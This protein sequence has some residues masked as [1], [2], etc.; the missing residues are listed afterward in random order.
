MQKRIIQ[1]YLHFVKTFGKTGVNCRKVHLS[2]SDI[3][4]VSGEPD[5]SHTEGGVRF[6]EPFVARM[7]YRL[8]F[9]KLFKT[10]GFTSGYAPSVNSRYFRC[11]AAPGTPLIATTQIC[12]IF[13]KRRKHFVGIHLTPRRHELPAYLFCEDK[14]ERS[15]C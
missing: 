8:S 2:K 13:M 14:Y 11:A 1:T 5:C 10:L 6:Q 4:E 12:H 7:S 15:V 3:F 9:L